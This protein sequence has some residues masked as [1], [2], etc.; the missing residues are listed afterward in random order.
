LNIN[1]LSAHASPGMCLAPDLA[2]VAFC[3]AGCV[4]QT[5]RSFS[6]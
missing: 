2:P 5:F 3:A 4:P 6:K 1:R